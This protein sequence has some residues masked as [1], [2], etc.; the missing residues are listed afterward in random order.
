MVCFFMVVSV[1]GWATDSYRIRAESLVEEY[2]KLKIFVIKKLKCSNLSTATA[3][4]VLRTHNATGLYPSGE[5]L[6]QIFLITSFVDWRHVKQTSIMAERYVHKGSKQA[7]IFR[8][9]Q[10][11]LVVL[12]AS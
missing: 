4:L 12:H 6:I 9:I 5:C 3:K 11:G 7:I 1:V 10:G 2:I 8:K